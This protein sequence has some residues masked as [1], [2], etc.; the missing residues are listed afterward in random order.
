M[1]GEKGQFDPIATAE[2]IANAAKAAADA[3]EHSKLNRTIITIIVVVLVFFS[4]SIF[5]SL[6]AMYFNYLTEKTTTYQN[7]AD[8]VNENN[9]K[10]DN[11]NLE[12]Q[13]QEQ[14][15]EEK[16]PSQSTPIQK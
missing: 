14:L 4:I 5:F 6:S 16:Q 2:Q 11:L 3:Q 10:I 15:L 9:Q 13:K 8:K 1:T 12:M 7:L